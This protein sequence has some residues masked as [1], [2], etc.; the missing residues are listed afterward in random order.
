MT[1]DR[2]NLFVPTA[3]KWLAS[4]SAAADDDEGR[5]NL[6]DNLHKNNFSVPCSVFTLLF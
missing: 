1:K 2:E 5:K 3:V 6:R 4:G